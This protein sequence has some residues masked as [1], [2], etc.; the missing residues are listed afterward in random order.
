MKDFSQFNHNTCILLSLVYIKN[1]DD[2][3]KAECYLRYIK[4]DNLNIN[5][6]KYFTTIEGVKIYD[7]NPILCIDL[8]DETNYL[9]KSLMSILN[10]DE[11]FDRNK[12]N[13]NKSYLET[14]SY[15][16]KRFIKII[17]NYKNKNN[18][19]FII[20]DCYLKINNNDLYYG[21][22]KLIENILE[23]REITID[24]ADNNEDEEDDNYSD[25][26]SDSSDDSGSDDNDSGSDDNDSDNDSDDNDSDDNSDSDDDSDGDSDDDSDD[27]DD[28]DS[29]DN[30][31]DDNDCVIVD[32]EP[33]A[34]RR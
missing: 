9:R 13:M 3:S 12:K 34:K 21:N 30:D 10:K 27:S 31:S 28:N 7:I 24:E 25:N 4:R 20:N 23:N 15:N 1:E 5:N 11:N 17:N 16:I 26:N 22:T 2:E 32:D 8:E 6:F 29:Y 19:N 18:F 33:P 14:T